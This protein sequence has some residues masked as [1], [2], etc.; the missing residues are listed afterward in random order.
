MLRDERPM[1]TN[2][3]IPTLRFQII[4]GI[5]KKGEGGPTDNLNIKNGE[6]QIK[7]GG[8][9]EKC[10]QCLSLI[11]GVPNKTSFAISRYS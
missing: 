3:L 9:S 6:V 7:A 8:G 4:G 2:K 1:A 5:L 11:M 10:S